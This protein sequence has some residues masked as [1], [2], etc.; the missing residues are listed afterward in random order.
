MLLADGRPG[1]GTHPTLTRFVPQI[2]DSVAFS[3]KTRAVLV[4]RARVWAV[5]PKKEPGQEPGAV[6]WEA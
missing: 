1:P 3:R 2:G 6:Q 5:G 4:T